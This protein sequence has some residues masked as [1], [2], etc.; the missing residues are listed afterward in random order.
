MTLEIAIWSDL[1]AAE[2]SALLRRPALRSDALVRRRVSKIIDK[3]RESGDAGVREITR[4]LDGVELERFR[5]G[6][7]EFDQAERDLSAA[8]I[9]AIELAISNVR[10]FHEKQLPASLD[11]EPMPGI[12]CERL[13]RPIDSVG[14]YVP[15]GSAP[16]PSAAIMLAVPAAIAGCPQRLMCT[17]PRPGGNADSAVLVAA[18]RSGISSVFKIGGAQ[19]IAAMAYGTVSMPKV[20]KI[21]GPGNAWVTVAK[22]IVSSDP[23]GAAIDMPAGPSEVL[24]IADESARAEFVAADLLSQAEHGEDSQ[25]ILITTSRRLGESIGRQIAEQLVW[26]E[27]RQ[28]VEKAL[29]N[30]RSIIAPDLETALEI[31]NS[32]APEHLIIQTRNPREA[33]P[34]IRNAG[35]VFLGPWSPESAGDYCTGTNHVLPTYGFA[36][37]YSGL[38]V[39]QFMRQMAIQELSEEGLRS[40]APAVT[41]MAR[42]EGLGAHAEAVRRR[43]KVR[44]ESAA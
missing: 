41:E 43:I 44:K 13:N 36:R 18:R 23:L 8:A 22:S 2:R 5:V 37:S 19:A 30:S 42:L 25:A 21:F 9:D 14:L 11:L 29:A 28:I 31:S 4:R 12:R 6:D 16:L 7:N 20:N 40:I 27:R 1:S 26:L 17:P 35:S 33:L 34:N 39:E 24:V 38:G 32:Y 3:V 10:C 15:A